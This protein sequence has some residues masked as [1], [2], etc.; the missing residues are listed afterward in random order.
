[1]G[2][3]DFELAESSKTSL[4]RYERA[5]KRQMASE[6][7]PSSCAALPKRLA[8]VDVIDPLTSPPRVPFSKFMMES[9]LKPLPI[10][11][12]NFSPK[13]PRTPSTPSCSSQA[14]EQV[15]SNANEGTL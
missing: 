8:G 14:D 6:V 4:A 15:C 3:E 1:M 11:E 5:K 10:Y 7:Q 12:I 9:P 13:L 2:H